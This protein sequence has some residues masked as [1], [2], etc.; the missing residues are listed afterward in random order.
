MCINTTGG[1]LS[2]VFSSAQPPRRIACLGSFLKSAG[3]KTRS[4][5]RARWI[6]SL[7]LFLSSPS[8][9][10]AANPNHQS[11]SLSAGQLAQYP[12][13]IRIHNTALGAVEA[14]TDGGRQWRLIGR[15]SVPAIEAGETADAIAAPSLR[16]QGNALAIAIP[17]GRTFSLMPHKSGPIP[18]DVLSIEPG[19]AFAVL[20]ELVALDTPAI[21]LETAAR[22]CPLYE[23]FAPSDGDVLVLGFAPPAAETTRVTRLITDAATSYDTAARKRY[24]ASNKSPVK[25]YLT[26]MAKPQQIEEGAPVLFLLDGSP[27][28]L[29]N[30]AP[31]IVKWDSR[32]W[33][34]GEHMIEVR[35]LDR[36]G[37]PISRAKTLIYVENRGGGG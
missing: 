5:R 10:A 12:V 14:T 9:P 18:R 11:T 17:P 33:R 2:P 26:V 28:A 34:D 31:Y 8:S 22:A 29:I 13:R 32:D 16:T 1:P 19:A 23:G 37:N 6:A 27:V 3:R 15:T 35:S 21:W 7:L 20:T 25:G 30:R 4:W 24:T 36:G